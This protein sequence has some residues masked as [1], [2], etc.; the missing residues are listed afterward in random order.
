MKYLNSILLI[1]IGSL[2]TSCTE[3][4]VQSQMDEYIVFYY[5]TTGE[6]FYDIVF[7]W[8]SYVIDTGASMDAQLH[9]DSEP[10]KGYIS[11][12]PF[13]DGVA[14]EESLPIYLVTPGGEVWITDAEDIAKTS[15]REEVEV[16]GSDT[17]TT[18]INSSLEPIVDHFK[19]SKNA[20]KKYGDLTKSGD[21]YSLTKATAD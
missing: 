10:Y 8:G 15:S 18:T 5:P 1:V 11:M 17:M 21:S 12:R 16:D 20:W 19:T 4:T 13:V 3:K 2:V 14:P 9:A 6:V 7:D